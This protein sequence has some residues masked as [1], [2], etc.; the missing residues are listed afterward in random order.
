[1]LRAWAQLRVPRPLLVIV[2][3]RH[4]KYREAFDLIRAL[5]LEQDVVI[6][7]QVSDM[8]LPAIYRNAKGFL[9][10][11]WAEGFGNPLLEAMA[12]GIPVVS[13]ANTALSEV[14]GGAALCVDPGNPSEIAGAILA[15]D[16]QAGLRE[17]MIH[18]GLLRA[19]EFTWERPAQTV[20]SVYMR[21]FGLLPDGSEAE[22]IG[23]LTR[24]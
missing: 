6:L 17:R 20:R 18:R 12:S 21:H 2:G 11:S 14:C 16:H 22:S 7:E 19:G 1:M 13:C 10:C 24:D 23:G 15:L 9:Y 5:R 4:F 8:E 3:Q